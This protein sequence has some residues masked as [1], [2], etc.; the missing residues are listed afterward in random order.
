MMDGA[1]GAKF[2]SH[3]SGNHFKKTSLKN[4]YIDRKIQISL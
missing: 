2:K 4:S 3:D 1:Y